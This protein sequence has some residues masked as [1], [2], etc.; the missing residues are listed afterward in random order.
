MSSGRY[1]HDYVGFILF[2]PIHIVII[3]VNV[4]WDTSFVLD[5]QC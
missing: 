4:L 3:V 5:I 1:L 2:Y